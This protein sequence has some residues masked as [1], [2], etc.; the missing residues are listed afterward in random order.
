MSLKKTQNGS[1]KKEVEM[2]ELSFWNFHE[3]NYEDENYCLYVMKNGLGDVLYV[4]ISTD[5]VWGRW[6]GWGGHMM[7][8]GNVI[9]GESPVSAKIENHLPDSLNWKI[10]LWTLN[11]CLIFCGGKPYAPKFK[12]TAGEYHNAVHAVEILVIRKLSPA[13]NS[14]LNLNPGKDTTPKSGN[15]LKREKFVD[16]VYDD[17]FNKKNK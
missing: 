12:M 16:N 10:Q 5:D 17:I 3:Q 7:W 6:F 1:Q 15:E 14:H 11:D 4:G 9:Y 13:L 2:I 8:D